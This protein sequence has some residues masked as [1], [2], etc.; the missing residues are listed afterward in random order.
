MVIFVLFFFSLC[1]LGQNMKRESG[2]K[3]QTGNIT[4]AKVPY[5]DVNQLFYYFLTRVCVY[6]KA[7]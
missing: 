3:V 7:E 4:A 2:R 6:K 5:S 1:A